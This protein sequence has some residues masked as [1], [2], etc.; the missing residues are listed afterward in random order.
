MKKTIKNKI[1]LILFISII[2]I[3]F[4]PFFNIYSGNVLAK[5]KDNK[6]G[7]KLSQYIGE[8]LREIWISKLTEFDNSELDKEDATVEF[9]LY[10]FGNIDED[11]EVTETEGGADFGN[12]NIEGKIYESKGMFLWPTPKYTKITSKYG[13]RFHPI[14][15]INKLHAG[16]DIGAPSGSTICAAADGVV[17]Y[18]SLSR[19]NDIRIWKFSNYRS[20]EMDIRL[21][22]VMG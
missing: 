1:R 2:C 7:K 22:M 20:S 8:F 5:N 14:K 18:A 11:R 9:T 17:Q 4:P 3:I 13:W 16:I 15:K 12:L 6:D 21:G 10:D 19:N